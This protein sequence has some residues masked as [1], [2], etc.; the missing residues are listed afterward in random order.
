MGASQF[1]AIS[2]LSGRCKTS[3][4]TL[5][6]F[7]MPS[8]TFRQSRQRSRRAAAARQDR[9][10]RT[11][12]RF[13][14]VKRCFSAQVDPDTDIDYSPAGTTFATGPRAAISCRS[15]KDR[16]RRLKR[17]PQ[18]W[19]ARH[20]TESV[21]VRP[22]NGRIGAKRHCGRSPRATVTGRGCANTRTPHQITKY[23]HKDRSL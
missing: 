1:I 23:Q 22:G 10:A 17:H 6:P 11:I 3:Y 15:I 20:P 8:R 4:R 13:F 12:G 14:R 19:S 5:K 21:G 18:G 7:Q 9:P 16:C 2:S